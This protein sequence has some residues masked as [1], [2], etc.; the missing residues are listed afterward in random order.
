[1]SYVPIEK[2]LVSIGK[3]LTNG[4]T[5]KNVSLLYNQILRIIICNDLETY[6]SLV[7]LECILAQLFF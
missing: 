3:W 6:A 4:F 5:N 7:I 2:F 1:M